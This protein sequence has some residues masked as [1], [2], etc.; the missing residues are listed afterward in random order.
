[1]LWKNC[2]SS[3]PQKTVLDYTEQG[4]HLTQ[5]T[6]T[7]DPKELEKV[8]LLQGVD[9]ESIQHLLGPCTVRHLKPAEVLL[10]SGNPN[11]L[12][13]ALLSGRLRIH[14]DLEAAPLALFRAA[15]LWRN[16]P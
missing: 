12:M 13:Y 1:M 9:I 3:H 11:R 7:W 6:D 5:P 16:F 8:S 4:V 2:S 15:K 14:L 10:S